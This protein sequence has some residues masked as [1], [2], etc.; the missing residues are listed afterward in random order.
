MRYGIGRPLDVLY[1]EVR[2]V[3]DGTA[4]EG[5]ARNVALDRRVPHGEIIVRFYRGPSHV[6]VAEERR[7]LW[8]IRPGE[9]RWFIIRP[10]LRSWQFDWVD[11][12]AEAFTA[13]P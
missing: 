6:L 1:W 13:Q 2:S 5:F 8:D 3:W 7:D 12:R 9:E 4:I 11:L 10:P